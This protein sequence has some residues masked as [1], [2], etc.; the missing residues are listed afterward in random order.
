M[1]GSLFP[2]TS[3]ASMARAD[4]PST[5][6]A[7]DASLMLAPSSTLA[8]RFSSAARSRIRLVRYRVSSR[9]S[10][11]GRSGTKLARSRPCRSRSAIHSASRM[12][13]LRPGTALRWRALA[14]SSSKLPSSTLYTGF[15]N[16]P[17]ASMATRLT[18]ASASQAHS[19][20]SSRVVGAEAAQLLERVA[21]GTGRDAAGHD[22][23]L[24]DV[25][26]GTGGVDDIHGEHVPRAATG[27]VLTDT[28]TASRAHPGRGRRQTVMPASTQVQLSVGLRRTRQ[29][30]TFLAAGRMSHFLHRRWGSS[31][32]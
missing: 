23:P 14:T 32:E 30:T 1:A 13:V 16:E 12:S 7:T 11:S 31:P 6:E 25:Q 8:M 3:P 19:A 17:V 2:A 27:R 10:R 4:T 15:P 28:E 5:P 29:T 20:S 21:V 24:V 22:R 18:P 26:A 9:S